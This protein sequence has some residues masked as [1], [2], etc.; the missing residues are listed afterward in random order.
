[1]RTTTSLL[2]VLLLLGATES[3]AGTLAVKRVE[4]ITKRVEPVQLTN[5]HAPHG[6]VD[7][8]LESDLVER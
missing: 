3:A 7:G 2:L 1:M 5:N 4:E 8:D 6:H